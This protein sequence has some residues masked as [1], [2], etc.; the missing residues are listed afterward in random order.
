MRLT[1]SHSRKATH[2]EHRQDWFDL[3]TQLCSQGLVSFPHLLFLPWYQLPAQGD[4]QA[5]LQNAC[6]QH[7]GDNML[8]HPSLRIWRE[9]VIPFSSCKEWGTYFFFPQKL[10]EKPSLYLIGM[11]WVVCQCS[12]WSDRWSIW[13]LVLKKKK[14]ERGILI[15]N[16]KIIFLWVLFSWVTSGIDCMALILYTL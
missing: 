15:G 6:Q 8:P 9:E 2:C 7:L 1:D 16:A 11:T 3:R 5:W 10:S 12:L 14:R 13:N 4:C